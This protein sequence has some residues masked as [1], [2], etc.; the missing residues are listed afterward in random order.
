MTAPAMPTAPPPPGRQPTPSRL[1]GIVSVL[2]VYLLV[3]VLFGIGCAV[4][5]KF[6]TRVNLLAALQSVTLIGIVAVGVAFITYSRHYVDLSIPGIVALSGVVAVWALQYGFAASMAAGLAAGLLVGVVNGLAVG[7][8]RLNPI[9]WTLAMGSV[10]PGLIRWVY[11]GRQLYPDEATAAG[12][13][14]RELYGCL[15]FGAAPLPAVVLAAA[16][17]G[18]YFLMHHT[19]YGASLKLTGSNYEAARLSGVPVRRVV[20]L[21]FVI[22]SLASAVAGILVTSF[23]KVGASDLGKG[24]DF[25]AITAVV[26]GGMTLAGGRGNILGVLGG[27]MA[28]AL[29]T[30]VMSLVR[31][32]AFELGGLSV[33]EI[34]L[35]EFQQNIIRG[36]VFILI[37]GL[38]SYSLRKAGRDDS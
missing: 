23:N 32:P 14:F 16:A 27:V 24:Y 35:G 20:C 9:I 7:Y 1:M 36:A 2:G 26:L 18:G 13:A 29:L 22:S 34:T 4:S 38:H 25:T 37:V 10:L 30:S 21:A 15:V 6:L 12:R 3:A 5:P 19:A 31:V 28:M 11:E 8:L 33:P 17:A